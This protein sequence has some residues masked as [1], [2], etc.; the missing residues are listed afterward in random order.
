[1]LNSAKPYRFYPLLH[2][3]YLGQTVLG[4]PHFLQ[5]SPRNQRQYLLRKEDNH[6]ARQCQEAVSPL[7]G[8][9][10]FQ[11]QPD[12]HDTETQQNQTDCPNKPR[13]KIGKVVD[14]LQRVVAR[15]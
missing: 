2:F 3:E 12:L 1:M 8:I 5:S 14:C 11:G 9:V 15:S 13:D 4:L 7:A 6:A 10:V